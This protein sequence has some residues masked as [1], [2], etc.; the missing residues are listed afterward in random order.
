LFSYHLRGEIM[1]GSMD[2]LTNLFSSGGESALAPGAGVTSFLSGK[3]TYGKLADQFLGANPTIPGISEMGGYQGGM[4][5]LIQPNQDELSRQIF[6][7]GVG[8]GGIGKIPGMKMPEASPPSMIPI[9]SMPAMA[10][11][12]MA[13]PMAPPR[14]Q[15]GQ[16][17]GLAGIPPAQLAKA[18]AMIK[19]RM[20]IQ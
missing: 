16:A 20:G 10:A 11:P 1:N 2:S 18:M 5:S 17:Q 4:S 6:G 15:V 12:Q 19:Q 7:G 9:Q 3:D 14:P 13:N 8:G